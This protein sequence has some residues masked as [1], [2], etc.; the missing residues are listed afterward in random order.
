MI[1]HGS[2]PIRPAAS[3]AGHERMLSP[4]GGEEGADHIFFS[5]AAFTCISWS[6]TTPGLVPMNSMPAVMPQ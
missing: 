6:Q 2:K 1:E 5:S 4:R 3:T